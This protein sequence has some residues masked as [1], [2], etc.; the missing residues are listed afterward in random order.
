MRRLR[1]LLAAPALAL[2]LLLGGFGWFLLA[3]ARPPTEPA[4]PVDGI[5]VLTGGAERIATGLRLLQAGRGGRMLISG[6]HPQVALPDVA[7]AAGV[8]PALLEGRVS[9]GHRATTTRG[10]ADEIADWA[11][12]EGVGSMVIVTAAYHMPR[13]LLEVRRRLP[14]AALL[15]Y[16]VVPAQLRGP[17]AGVQPRTWSLLAGEYLKLLA[18][19]AGVPDLLGMPAAPAR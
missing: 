7:R 19:A 4:W 1:L 14:G 9:L 15:P 16:P 3:L 6:V 10:N 5:V 8:D 12:A 2:L 11:R 18:V 13:A 17:G